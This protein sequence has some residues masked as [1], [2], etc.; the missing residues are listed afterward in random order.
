MSKINNY[1]EQEREG[2]EI[3]LNKTNEREGILKIL[4]DGLSNLVYRNRFLDVGAGNPFYL[5]NE[6]KKYFGETEVIEPNE[7]YRK[8]HEKYHNKIIGKLLEETSL[9]ENY[10]DFVLMS[11]V[12]YYVP[13]NSWRDIFKELIKSLTLSGSLAIIAHSEKSDTYKIMQD[14][15]LTKLSTSIESI[16]KFI[17]NKFLGELNLTYY[18]GKIGPL[19][20]EEYINLKGFLI[21][22]IH[23][24]NKKADIH[25]NLYKELIDNS[26]GILFIKKF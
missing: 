23:S 19:T 5:T 24:K 6:I 4:I 26:G 8:L 17:E 20:K 18:Y 11:H 14:T 21:K 16:K 12:L 7:H 22:S 2:F 13:Q 9:K 25:Q 10:Y 15:S 1:W 3:L